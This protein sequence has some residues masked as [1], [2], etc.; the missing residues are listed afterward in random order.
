[1]S[2]KDKTF[3]H[4]EPK[5]LANMDKIND[6]DLTHLMY[7]YSVRNVG[8]PELH[9]AFENK[10]N[11]IAERLDYPALFNAKYYMLFR[12]NHNKEIW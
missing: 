12:E 4:M 3:Y 7:A 8:N 1:M 11:Q 9:K 10:L 5:I 2:G 6:R